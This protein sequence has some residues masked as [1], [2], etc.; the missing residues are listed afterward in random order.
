MP[1]ESESWLATVARRLGDLKDQMVFVG[2]SVIGLLIDDPASTPVRPTDD[3]DMIVAV[4]SRQRYDALA[5]RL[6]ILGFQPDVSK[7][8]PLCRWTI[9][10]VIVDIMPTSA[11]ILGFTNRWYDAAIIHAVEV[12]IEPGLS[13]KLTTAPYFVAM[14]LEAFAGR[15]NE[16][17]IA[18]HDLE[19]IVAVVDARSALVDEIERSPDDLRLYLAARIKALLDEDAFV[20]ALPGHLAGDIASQSRLPHVLERLRRIAIEPA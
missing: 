6:R 14:K 17:Y 18:S 15:G 1:S 10:G 8:A 16:D 20:D 3:L 4:S 12:E 2:G 11:E 7:G 5:T 13:I 19:D 9:E